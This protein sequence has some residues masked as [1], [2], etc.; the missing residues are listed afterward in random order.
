MIFYKSVELKNGEK[1]LLRSPGAGDAE[2]VLGTFIKTHGESDFMTTYPDECTLTAEKEQSYL[3]NKLVAEREIEIAADIGGRIVGT[4]GI[5]AVGKAEKLR[6]RASFGIGI[7]KEFWG[8]G[9]GR[10]L[11]LACIECAK[12]AGYLQLELEV[13]A[14]NTR[15]IALYKSLGF[16]EYGR[17]PLGFRS[18]ENG[19]QEIV[20]MRLEL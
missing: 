20:A 16:T 19:M 11:T 1:C 18:R 4:A 3:E 2:A 14:A 15:A 7:E 13:V 10:A 9:V 6:H 5:E 12:Q 17:N 8:V